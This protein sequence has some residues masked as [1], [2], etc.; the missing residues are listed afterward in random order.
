MFKLVDIVSKG[1]NYLLNV[2][3]DG[4]GVIPPP[5]QDT[6]RGVGRWLHANGEAIYGVGRTP[7][8]EEFGKAVQAAPDDK[9]GPRR[10]WRCEACGA[11]QKQSSHF[12][13]R[14]EWRC[15][16]QPGKLYI[17][18]FWW[19]A[20]GKFELPAVNG[21]IGKAYLL[22]DPQKAELKT[23]QTAS[24]VSIDLPLKAPDPIATVVCLETI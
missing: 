18:I 8:G 21:R 15:T 6:L 24:G 4:T 23:V 2:G 16:T 14:T 5:S 12:E 7:F 17:H 13:P 19:P 11:V 1:G 10:E 20:T 22:T 3:P 9:T